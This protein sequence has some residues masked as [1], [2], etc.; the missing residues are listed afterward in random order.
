MTSHKTFYMC[1]VI[2]FDCQMRR[3]VIS[4]RMDK[5]VLGIIIELTYE[6]FI[7]KPTTY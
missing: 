5:F 2:F 3:D 6:A 4:K 1:S 7:T